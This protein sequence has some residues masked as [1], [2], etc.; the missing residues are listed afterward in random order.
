MISY[1]LAMG[2]SLIALLMLTGSLK[3]SVIVEQQ[4]T[5]RADLDGM[6]FTS[7]WDF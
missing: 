4:A 6:F 7:R 2:L 5:G 3:M 1:E